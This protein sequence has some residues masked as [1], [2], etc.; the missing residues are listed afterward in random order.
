MYSKKVIETFKN[1]KFVGEIKN[2]DAV[3]QVGNIKCGDMMKVFLKVKNNRIEDI[4]VQTYG[5]VAAIASSDTM[6]KLVKGKTLEEAETLTYKKIIEDLGQMPKIKYHCSIMGTEALH[7]AIQNYRNSSSK[8]KK[9]ENGNGGGKMNYSDKSTL[10][11]VLNH[12]KGP[13]LL[14]KYYVP[15]ISCHMASSELDSLTLKDLAGAYGINIKGL[16]NDL[17]SPV[18]EKNKQK[19]KKKIIKSKKKVIVTKKKIVKKKK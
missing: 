19:T 15:C 2:A 10:G 7:K 5:C 17:N 12:K 6:C 18:S 11:E 8:K 13:E 1:P 3:G 14:A 4:K 16:I 9:Q